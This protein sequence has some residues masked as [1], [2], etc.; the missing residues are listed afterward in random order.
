MVFPTEL[1]GAGIGATYDLKRGLQIL[2]R[3][4]GCQDVL[5]RWQLS[6]L[7]IILTKSATKSQ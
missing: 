1:V 6:V 2:R 5:G 4:V 7:A 3:V